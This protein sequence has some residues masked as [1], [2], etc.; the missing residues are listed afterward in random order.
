MRR[1]EAE[2]AI[3]H[4]AGQGQILG[5]GPQR[6]NACQ[7]IVVGAF[8]SAALAAQAVEAHV[9]RRG[10]Q[11]ASRRHGIQAGFSS[12]QL[13]EDIVHGV[14]GFA[15]IPQKAA[16]TTQDHGSVRP[17][18][19]FDVHR[20]AGLLLRKHRS[21]GKVLLRGASAGQSCGTPN[22]R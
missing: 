6:C 4:P 19:A 8:G 17:V 21:V 7:E 5:A 14:H 16:T 9:C 2:D 18:E 11:Q 1:V 12:Q 3:Q 13:N 10:Q 22:S 15:F 20:H